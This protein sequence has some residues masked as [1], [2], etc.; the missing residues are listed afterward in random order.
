[1]LTRNKE[2]LVLSDSPTNNRIYIQIILLLFLFF[3]SHTDIY[4]AESLVEDEG[5]TIS[6]NEKDK[7][8]GIYGAVNLKPGEN[9]LVKKNYTF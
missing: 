9:V 2:N 3:I 8:E 7:N 6:E 4:T 1:M 5:K